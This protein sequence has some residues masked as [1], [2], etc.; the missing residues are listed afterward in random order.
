VLSGHG[1][2]PRAPLATVADAVV[3]HRVNERVVDRTVRR[4]AEQLSATEP[5]YL[6]IR[7][8]GLSQTCCVCAMS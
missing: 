6:W 1:N 4:V 7:T 5:E 3:G 8:Y 2:T